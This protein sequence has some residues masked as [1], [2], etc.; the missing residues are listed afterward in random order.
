MVGLRLRYSYGLPKLIRKIILQLAVAALESS[1]ALKT[2]SK[3]LLIELHMV[4][5]EHARILM[6]T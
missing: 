1:S 5:I 4:G 2:W 6:S 3:T